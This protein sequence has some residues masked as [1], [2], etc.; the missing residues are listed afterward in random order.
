MPSISRDDHCSPAQVSYAELLE[1]ILDEDWDIEGYELDDKSE[2]GEDF[3]VRGLGPNVTCH[4]PKKAFS[5]FQIYT[6]PDSETHHFVPPKLPTTLW[7][8]VKCNP[9]DLYKQCLFFKAQSLL[10]LP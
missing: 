3:L 8:T 4:P 7:D 6:P 9:A 10:I 1:N 5:W 2:S